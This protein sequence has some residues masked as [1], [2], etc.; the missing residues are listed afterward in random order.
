VGSKAI[1]EFIKSKK[2]LL[3]L[4]GH[5]HETA[6]ISGKFYEM[7]GGGLSATAGN[8]VHPNKLAYLV[9]EPNNICV[10]LE[11]QII[12]FVK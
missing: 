5:I 7:I 6:D 1:L 2:P 11:R 4:S 12:E 8:G 9:F 10:T 3:T